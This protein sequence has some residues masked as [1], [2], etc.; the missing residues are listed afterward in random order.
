MRFWM[1]KINHLH[2][3]EQSTR[4][5][6]QGL[7]PKERDHLH[8]KCRTRP[9][10]GQ[11]RVLH[12]RKAITYTLSAKQDHQTRMESCTKGRW[13]LTNWV[14]NKHQRIRTGSCTKERWSLTNW[15]QN[16]TTKG[17]K[18]G[19]APKKGDHLHPECRTRPSEVKIGSCTKGKGSLTPW[20]QNK[21]I[22]GSG[23]GLAP[24]KGDHLH[25]ECRT[26]PSGGQDGVLGKVKILTN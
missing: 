17:L 21:A 25:P 19:L 22:R 10:E 1:K 18:Q 15:V 23:L 11:N 24:Q 12:Q 5:S 8:T 16:K 13:S 6:K 3:A 2:P 4:G 14:Q 26:R 20:V 7:P 9:S